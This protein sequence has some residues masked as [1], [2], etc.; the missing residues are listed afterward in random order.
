MVFLDVNSFLSPR[1]GGA[2]TYHLQKAEW[3]ARH[4][5]HAYLVLGPGSGSG[6]ENLGESEFRMRT[7]WGMPYGRSSNYRILLD[8][9]EADRLLEREKVGILEVGDPWLTAR[10]SS[11]RPGVVRT[12]MWHSDPHTAYLEPWAGRSPWRR[13]ATRIVLGRVD[14]WHRHFDRIWCASEWVAGLLR[15]RG[16]PNVQRIRFGIEKGRFRPL[17]SDPSLLAKFGMDP[18]RPVLLYAGRLDIEKGV[19]T[20]LAAI[21]PILALPERPQVLVTG[22]GEY[23]ERFRGISLPGYAFG[24]FLDRDE[25]ATLLSSSTLLLATCAV[26]TFG[27]GVLEALCAGLPVVSADGGGGSEQVGESKAGVLF[28]S[29]DASDLVNGV[30]RALVRRD[31]FA[32][33]ARSWGA[34]W[35]SWDDMFRAQTESCLEMARDRA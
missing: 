35:P 22:R 18:N 34:S 1:G 9:S 19:E 25:L 13:L 12:C 17:P 10:W 30:S 5:E 7:S 21:A 8:Y 24:G 14:A 2:R 15:G 3:F 29:G 28:R 11:R 6:E 26:E 32:S 4:D 31:E 33:R 27:L 16:Y 20:L 23:E